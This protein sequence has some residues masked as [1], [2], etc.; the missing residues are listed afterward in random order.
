MSHIVVVGVP[1]GKSFQIQRG[2]VGVRV[3]AVDSLQQVKQEA[4]KVPIDGVVLSEKTAKEGLS[5][6]PHVI[7]VSKTLIISG[8]PS[9]QAALDTMKW[10]LGKFDEREAKR[11]LQAFPGL[12]LE[13]YVELKFGEFV[14]TMKASS[15]KGL[16]VTLI[17]AVER[18][19]IQHALHETNGNQV[20]AAKLLGMNRNTLRKKI[21]EYHISV[22]RRSRQET[23]S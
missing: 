5:D 7:D 11:R 10:L 22:P 21:T 12:T 16:H 15:A 3:V 6:L 8:P 18:P 9:L 2:G 4:Q 14:H 17:Q 19:L 20:Q 1:A 13:D 23:E